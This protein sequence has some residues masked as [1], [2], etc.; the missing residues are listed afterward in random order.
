MRRKRRK[1]NLN[2]MEAMHSRLTKMKVLE[3]FPLCLCQR[4]GDW[5]MI[6]IF[7]QTWS[8]N[9]QTQGK[10]VETRAQAV[11]P[12]SKI[13]WWGP[14]WLCLWTYLVVE[15]VLV[16]A[17]LQEILRKLDLHLLSSPS[18]LDLLLY[19]VVVPYK[20]KVR[21]N[22]N[23]FNLFTWTGRGGGWASCP[24]RQRQAWRKDVAPVR[25]HG[26][27]LGLLYLKEIIF[28]AFWFLP[29]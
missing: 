28:N 23:M 29:A 27:K 10:T 26:Y 17:A 15:H 18:L 25:H 4:H 20:W 9:P 8:T 5:K 3:I 24:H 13:T 12:A 14:F 21:P 19:I 1:S 22:Y 6:R 2:R 11:L 16:L 7:R